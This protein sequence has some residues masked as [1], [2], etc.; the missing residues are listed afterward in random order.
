MIR[1]RATRLFCT[2]DVT[3]FASVLLVLV[4]AVLI[5][6]VWPPQNVVATWLSDYTAHVR[7]ARV[8]HG[9]E[10]EDAVVIVITL[11]GKV[12]FGPDHVAL[13]QLLP[14]IQE[15]LRRGAERRAYLVMDSRVRYGNAK[16][17]IEAVRLAG[18]EDVSF[19]AQQSQ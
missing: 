9:A 2:P 19:V 5:H 11:D 13:D 15:R 17:V 3:A 16:E 10:R 1:K 6:R 12:F 4:F 8:L 7:H 14:L 18:I